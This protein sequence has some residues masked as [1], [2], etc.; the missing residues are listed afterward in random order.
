MRPPVS[1]AAATAHLSPLVGQRPA[2]A[3]EA[4]LACVA[5]QHASICL[6]V[7]ESLARLGYAVAVTPLTSWEALPLAAVQVLRPD[8]RLN[9]AVLPWSTPPLHLWLS[10]GL[11][12]M[13]PPGELA[14]RLRAQPRQAYVPLPWHE[15]TLHA[16]VARVLGVS[17]SAGYVDG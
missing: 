8:G 11:L 10:L 17:Q 13:T 16:A 5:G 4:P 2:R 14:P 1:S 15:A 12:T 6:D 9:A 3:L 7:A